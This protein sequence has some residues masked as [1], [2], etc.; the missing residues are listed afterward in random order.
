M[1]GNYKGWS[2]WALWG[3]LVIC[4]AIIVDALFLRQFNLDFHYDIQLTEII[5]V[6]VTIILAL[7]LAH[8]VEEHREQKKAKTEILS[9]ILGGLLSDVDSLSNQIF[10]PRL[11]Y[12]RLSTFTKKALE[13]VQN[14]EEVINAL[15]IVNAEINKSI[16]AI[17]NKLQYM[18]P[19]LSDIKDK[20]KSKDDYMVVV[21]GVVKEIGD[22]RISGIQANLSD[23]RKQLCSVWLAVVALE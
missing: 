2:K 14:I 16:S 13:K 18:R 19:V 20:K 15:G 5:G 10:E 1:N 12:A 4:F 21:E 6:V 7:Y 11:Q 8:V 22:K 17:Q 9:S 3:A 23:L